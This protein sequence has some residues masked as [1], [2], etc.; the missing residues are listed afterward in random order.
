MTHEAY[1]V[2]FLEVACN[3]FYEYWSCLVYGCLTIYHM[4]TILFRKY[5]IS[6]D[7]FCL[8]FFKTLDNVVR[9]SHIHTCFIVLQ[10]IASY[11]SLSCYFYWY[12]KIKCKIWNREVHIIKWFQVIHF[13]TTRISTCKCGIHVTI[14]ENNHTRLECSSHLCKISLDEVRCIYSIKYCCR[15]MEIF[16]LELFLHLM[17]LQTRVPYTMNTKKSI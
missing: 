11:S 6:F 9:I 7:D 8:E 13:D 5:I 10:W 4:H 1:I 17:D 2:F 14:T 16:F 3:F 15:H 12:T